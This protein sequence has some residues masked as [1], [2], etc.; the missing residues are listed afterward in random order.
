MLTEAHHVT[1]RY[2]VVLLKLKRSVRDIAPV[3]LPNNSR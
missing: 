1:C 3:C 2:D